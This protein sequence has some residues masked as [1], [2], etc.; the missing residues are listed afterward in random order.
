MTTGIFE[1]AIIT[2]IAT[3]LG[4]AAKLFKQPIILAYLIAG[5]AIGYFGF[6]HIGDKEVFEIFSDLGIMFLLFLVGLEINY[7]SLRL[8]GKTSILI[9]LGQVLFTFIAG[10][11][12]ATLFN[13]SYLHAGYIAI[14]LTFSSTVIVVK[15]LSEKKDLNSLYGKIS[16]GLLLV[17]DFVAIMLLIFLAGIEANSNFSFLSIFLTILKGVALFA[18]MIYLGRKIMPKI[19]DKI[20]HSQELLFLTS[21]AWVFLISTLVSKTGFSIEIGGF[22]AGLALANSSESFQIA[23]RIKSLR[24][25]FI[26]IFF[27]ILGSS[28]IFSDFSGIIIPIIA[29]SLFVLIGNPLIIL[30]IMGLMGYKKRTSFLTGITIAQISEFSLILA[31]LG[32]K[33]NHLDAKVVSLI[34]TVGIITIISSTYFI[35]YA[36]KIF[37]LLNRFLSIFERQ[38]SKENGF[39]KK[40][41]AKPVILI[42]CHRTGQSIA[43]AIPKENLLVIDFDPDVINSLKKHGY[44]Y[45]F[46]DISDPEIFERSNIENSRFV[47][48][49][50][51]DIEDNLTILSLIRKLPN[52]PKII[53]RARTEKEARALYASGADY[54]LLPHFTAGQYLGKT[55]AIDPEMKILEQLKNKDLELME[56]INHQV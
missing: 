47:I 39:Y 27:V 13:F 46:G 51:P 31:G 45:I 33:L 29:F 18:L 36:D 38:K 30:I 50:S 8:V 6:F 23:S 24:D 1:L 26:L 17:Q 21:L 9:G 20:A 28:L 37:K 25:F 15:L 53:L 2:L 4:I 12:I 54:V 7:A 55:F 42:G 56:K 14:A 40:E 22:L 11:I 5:I 34:T 44:D 43:S 32:F 48:S 41:S 35:V 10:F 16:I 49:T 3:G 52:K 19:F